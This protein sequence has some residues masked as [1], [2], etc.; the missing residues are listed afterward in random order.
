MSYFCQPCYKRV[1]YYW[2]IIVV[3]AR[4]HLLNDAKTIFK[5]LVLL[6]G[7]TLDICD[8]SKGLHSYIIYTCKITMHLY[9]TILRMIG[10]KDVA[11]FIATLHAKVFWVFQWCLLHIVC[12]CREI[13]FVP[14]SGIKFWLSAFFVMWCDLFL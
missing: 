1:P 5:V 3:T 7:F 10:W 8:G 14:K 12:P 6:E 2:R 13:Y 9:L 11:N 4:K